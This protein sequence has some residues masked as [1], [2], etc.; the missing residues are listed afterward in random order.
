MKT[1]ETK[2]LEKVISQVDDP[3]TISIVVL[4]VQDIYTLIHHKD[5]RITAKPEYRVC[6]SKLLNSKEI[7]RIIDK[8]LIISTGVHEISMSEMKPQE[9]TKLHEHNTWEE[10]TNV[11]DNVYKIVEVYDTTDTLELLRSNKISFKALV[12]YLIDD[13]ST[14]DIRLMDLTKSTMFPI[15]LNEREIW[16]PFNNHAFVL[17]NTGAGKSSSYYRL[18]GVEPSSDVSYIGL[19][20]GFSITTRTITAGSLNGSGAFPMDEFPERKDAIMNQL[21][22]YTEHGE[23]IRSLVETIKCVGTKSLVFLGNCEEGICEGK[24]FKEKVIGL[25]TGKTLSRI[26]RRFAHVYYGNDFSTVKPVATEYKTVRKAR[27]MVRNLIDS[28]MKEL[29]CY[30]DYCK[31]W[32]LEDD[33]VYEDLFEYLATLTEH[34]S[35]RE[36][37][38]G[39]KGA[40]QKIKMAAAKLAVIDCFDKIIYDECDKKV[41]LEYAKKKYEDFKSYNAKS[42]AFLE[43]SKKAEALHMHKKGDKPSEIANKLGVHLATIYRWFEETGFDDKKIETDKRRKMLAEIAT[44]KGWK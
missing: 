1:S 35:L 40:V 25:A 14:K 8:R 3:K 38:L 22:N 30:I 2:R 4:D 20:G 7:I 31:E 5:Q 41:V 37:L 33:I 42:F 26:G 34:E 12:D 29:M 44:T 28:N 23:N 6:F 10:K 43:V 24:Q 17:T 18:T 13:T 9:V 21:L 16:Q 39:H 27:A 11:S 36:F 32:I 15:P 19:L